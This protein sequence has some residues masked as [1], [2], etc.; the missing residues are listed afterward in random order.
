MQNTKTKHTNKTCAL[1]VREV[2]YILATDPVENTKVL[3]WK[4]LIASK[5]IQTRARAR[6]C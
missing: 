3:G 2:I 5:V 1:N 6:L 4:T